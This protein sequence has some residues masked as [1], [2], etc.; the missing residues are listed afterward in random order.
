MIK[1]FFNNYLID[2]QEFLKKG[3]M[4]IFMLQKLQKKL[5]PI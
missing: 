5:L 3:I 4:E 1:L 2:D